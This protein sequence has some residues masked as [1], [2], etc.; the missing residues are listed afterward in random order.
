[1]KQVKRIVT[2]LIML[3]AVITI[4][5]SCKKNSSAADYN[6]D[7]SKLTLQIDSA[8]TLYNSATEG[9]QAGQY[10][11]GSKAVLK[12]AIT[13]ATNVTTGSYTQQPVVAYNFLL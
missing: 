2:A 10:S 11:V 3:T 1:M 4:F 7:K 5:Q 12:I 6:S 13:L 9:K 8:T